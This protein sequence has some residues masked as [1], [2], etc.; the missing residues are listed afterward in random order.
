M[1]KT[2]YIIGLII[3]FSCNTKNTSQYHYSTDLTQVENGSIP[4]ELEFSGILTDTAYFCLPKIIPGIYDD[5]NFGK[6]VN[7]F[8]AFNADGE[9]LDVKKIDV[10]CW[11]IPNAKE[12]DKIT[13]R[14]SQGWNNFDFED[15]RPYRAAESTFNK[16][17]F[18]L[19][20]NSIFGY[21]KNQEDLPYQI[22]VKKNENFY[23]ASS[24]EKQGISKNLDEFKA[25]DYRYLVDNPIMYSTPDTTSIT[26]PNIRVHIASYSSSGKK[27][28]DSLA[29][30][31][32][33]LL[34][35]QTEYL[36]GNLATDT[37]TFI[38][39]H[40]ENIE[41]ERFIADGLEHNQSTI[42]LMYCPLDMEMLKMSVFS[43]ASHEFFHTVQP[44][45]LHSYEI[46]NFD[47]SNPKFSK[48]L[49]LYEGTTEYFTIHM[50]IKQKMESLD[51]FIKVLEH[52]ISSMKAYS[53]DMPFTA[54]SK[55]VMDMPDD[56]MNVYF[57]GTLINLCLDIRL[58]ELSN[59]TYGVQDLIADLLNKYGKDKPFEDDGLFKEIYTVT[60]FPELEDFVKKYIAG[61]EPLPLK[62]V[63][64]KVGFH[65]DEK[66]GK[67]TEVSMVSTQQS[68]LRKH[69]INQ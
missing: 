31:I 40:N 10:N 13:Y 49:W 47:F 48:H 62:E 28:A 55:H 33:P 39:Y 69:W 34:K 17:V 19:N 63:L 32:A 56:Y 67:I 58:R 24:L 2:I 52:K 9:Y 25:K 64:L 11:Q 54:F 36:G 15:S 23:G 53:N 29:R 38:V 57:K 46:A 7:D 6:F 18:I 16:N 43:L 27:I 35:N 4:V 30:S 1:R 66:T 59:G 44:L 5:T 22:V 61:T 12:L 65:Y 60:G 50:R 42:L 14:A 41:N 68:T 26:L 21:F 51:E 45:G 37:Y 3:L 20:T 8:K